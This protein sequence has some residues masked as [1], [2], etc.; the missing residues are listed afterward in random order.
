MLQASNNSKLALRGINEEFYLFYQVWQELLEQRTL[1]T[2][3]Y[4]V[5]YSLKAIEE[6]ISVLENV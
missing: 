6:L 4:K 1:D 2:Y 5:L 3:Q